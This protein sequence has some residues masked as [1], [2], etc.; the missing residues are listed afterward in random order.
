MRIVRV[1]C[2]TFA[3]PVYNIMSD[4]SN[5]RRWCP[6]RTLFMHEAIENLK[7]QNFGAYEPIVFKFGDI[8]ESNVEQLFRKTPIWI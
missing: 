7:C 2:L 4:V 5:K 8:V 1:F 6:K 3:H